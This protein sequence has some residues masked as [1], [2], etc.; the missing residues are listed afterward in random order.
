ME[1]YFH[2]SRIGRGDMVEEGK[3]ITI[4]LEYEK[5]NSLK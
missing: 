1:I 3:S 5:Q 2:Q 4:G